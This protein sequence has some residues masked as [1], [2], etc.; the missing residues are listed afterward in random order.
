MKIKFFFCLIPIFFFQLSGVSAQNRNIDSLS[1]FLINTSYNF[2][3]P[4]GDFADR[5]GTS[6]SIGLGFD[7][8]TSKNYIFG[9][10]HEFIFGPHVKE[11]V[12]SNL[13]TNDGKIIGSDQL[14]TNV[15]LRE[16]G[17]SSTVFFGKLI[18]ISKSN[19]RS[20]IRF[21]LGPGF[22]VHKM[23]LLDEKKTVPQVKGDYAYGYDRLTWGFSASEFI[24]YQYLSKDNR[25]NFFVGVEFIQ[26][27]TKNQRAY[28]FN[29]MK[30]DEKKRLDLL[31]NF[32]ATWS[33]PFYLNDYGE[34]L[35]Y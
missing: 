11:D 8:I 19:R 23:R 27:F 29:T 16:R 21:T 5:F 35:S 13:R 32:K 24:G 1:V 30:H 14:L 4:G 7:L 22:L 10:N 31:F 9:T 28:D 25:I 20:G 18:P 12:L 2:Q 6:T 34:D 15:F 3:I 26:G 17:L 33:L